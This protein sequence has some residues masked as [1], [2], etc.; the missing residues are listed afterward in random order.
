[1]SEFKTLDEAVEAVNGTVTLT[2]SEWDDGF[3]WEI[4]V[5]FDGEEGKE[6]WSSDS[7]GWEDEI[8]PAPT[9]AGIAACEV[10]IEGVGR[11]GNDHDEQ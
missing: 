8:Y 5:I 3:T 9:L 4:H 2:I 6:E 11:K 1:M 7:E 10:A